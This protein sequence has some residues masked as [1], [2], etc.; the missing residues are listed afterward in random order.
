MDA[1]DGQPP[2]ATGSGPFFDLSFLGMGYKLDLSQ[3]MAGASTEDKTNKLKELLESSG[4]DQK[5]NIAFSDST[6]FFAGT[7]FELLGRA[8]LVYPHRASRAVWL[9]GSG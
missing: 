6:G 9:E 7:E 5:P 4:T 8:A 1:V 2:A 3:V